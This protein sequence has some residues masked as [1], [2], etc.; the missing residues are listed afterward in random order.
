[1]KLLPILF[2]V[3]VPFAACSKS[4]TE[5]VT[6]QKHSDEPMD[7]GHGAHH[8]LASVTIGAHTLQVAREGD[9]KAGAEAA[10]DLS[11]E[12]GKPL[13][14]MVRCWIGVESGEGSMKAK[15]SKENDTTVH[16]HVEVPK[17]IPAGAKLWIEIEEAGK[18]ARG[19]VAY[20]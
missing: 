12:K 16:G 7:H 5:T 18:T 4:G 10:F 13:P 19:A 8:E 11:V 3:V 17:T 2:A 1:M 9:V 20:Q 15:F 14:A 6:P